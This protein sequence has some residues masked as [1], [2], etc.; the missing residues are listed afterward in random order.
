MARMTEF[1]V[2]A[3]DARVLIVSRDGTIA[4]P[5]SRGPGGCACTPSASVIFMSW[6]WPRPPIAEV[7][8]GPEPDRRGRRYPQ[9]LAG[10]HESHPRR[11]PR[12]EE[13]RPRPDLGPGS[14]R[15]GLVAWKASYW[16]KTP[17][18]IEEHGGIL[19]GPHWREETS[20][21]R[22]FTAGPVAPVPGGRPARRQPE[23]RRRSSPPLPADAVGPGTGLHRPLTVDS[24]APG[25]VYGYSGVSWPRRTCRSSSSPSVRSPGRRLGPA[26]HGRRRAAGVQP[27]SAATDLG[28]GAAVTW[29]PFSEDVAQA[30]AQIGTLTL[31][32]DYEGW[33]RIVIEAMSCG[34]PVIMTDVGCA[35]EAMRDGIEGRV[36]PSAIKRLLSRR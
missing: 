26:S 21:N 7:G 36:V 35:N 34:I 23:N 2:G 14:A 17:L 11:H 25:N 5:K 19:L 20:K 3:R 32:S 15:A 1:C 8:I 27:A 4:D 24:K 29:I 16:T 10:P 13:V 12:P 9:P 30:Y 18:L 22:A 6:R 28:V 31:S 33:A